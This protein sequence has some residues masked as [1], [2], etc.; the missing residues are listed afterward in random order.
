MNLLVVVES[1]NELQ[2]FGSISEAI[3]CLRNQSDFSI[4]EMRISI[5]GSPSAQEKFFI[6]KQ[7]IV[8]G[9]DYERKEIQLL[10]ENKE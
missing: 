4:G 3:D 1:D 5:E 2:Y 7:I 8:S 9:K 10:M 6:Q